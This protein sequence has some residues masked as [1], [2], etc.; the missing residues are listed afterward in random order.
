MWNGD[1]EGSEC[2]VWDDE[3]WSHGVDGVLGVWNLGTTP[4]LFLVVTSN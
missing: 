1:F 2:G 4:L 3:A